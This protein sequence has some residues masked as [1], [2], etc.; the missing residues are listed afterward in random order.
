M[1]EAR[2]RHILE[3]LIF[4]SRI[5]WTECPGQIGWKPS[6]GVSDFSLQM[7]ESLRGVFDRPTKPKLV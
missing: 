6:A 7:S 5:H 2:L 4:P 3:F 1:Q